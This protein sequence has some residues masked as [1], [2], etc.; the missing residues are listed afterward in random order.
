TVTPAFADLLPR[1]IL[2]RRYVD[3]ANI[4]GVRAGMI[5]EENVSTA[6]AFGF[7]AHAF[8]AFGWTGMLVTSFLVGVLVIV[9]TPLLTRDLPGN[10]WAVVLLGDYQHTVAE[11]NIG[12]VLA[13]F[14][15]GLVWV[16]ASL[17]IV[18]TLAELW[19]L[20]G[21]ALEWGKSLARMR[22][23]GDQQGAASRA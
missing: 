1:L 15:Y 4:L 13:L 10:I 19:R 9:V 14:T 20:G 17:I 16:A 12:S 22:A 6:I 18:R 5:D 7:A 3:T 23:Q 8:F 2:P 11:G 21:Q